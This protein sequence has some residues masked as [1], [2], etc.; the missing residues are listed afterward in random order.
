MTEIIDGKL[1][2]NELTKNSNGGTELMARRMVETIPQEL[3]KGKQ[4]IHSRVREL[5]PDLKKVLIVHDLATDPEVANLADPSYRNQFEKIFFVS[6]WQQNAYNMVLGVPFSQSWVIQN[7]IEVDYNPIEKSMDG[8][9]RMIYHTTPHRGLELLVPAFEEA[10]KHFDI[11]LDVFSSFNAYGWGDRD[12]A[13]QEVFDRLN[14][15]K[16]VTNHGFQPNSIVREKLKET[17][18]FAYPCI[19]PETSCIALI[20]AMCFGNMSIHSSLGALPETSLAASSMYMYHEDINEHVNMFFR[21]LMSGLETL[22]Q[23]R[24]K[25]FSL[26][27]YRRQYV[28]SQYDWDNNVKQKWMLALRAI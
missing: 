21:C 7:G 25:V 18:L 4:I 13:F 28:C 27:E 20:E 8:P 17:H 6:H 19:W 11:H 2:Y 14:S 26:N 24:E 15:L 3:L 12:Q 16:N 10:S 5:I 9:I 22:T 23:H 1:V